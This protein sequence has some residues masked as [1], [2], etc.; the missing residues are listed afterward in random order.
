MKG[1][2]DGYFNDGL[3]QFLNKKKDEREADDF[4]VKAINSSLKGIL[5]KGKN[6]EPYTHQSQTNAIKKLPSLTSSPNKQYTRSN[7]N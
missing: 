6:M 5:K 1:I 2:V 3:E 4:Q 7:Q